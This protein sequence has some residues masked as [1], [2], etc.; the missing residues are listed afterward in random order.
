MGQLVKA[1][2]QA[3]GPVSS[4]WFFL[5]AF[6]LDKEWPYPVGK[7]MEGYSLC[8]NFQGLLWTLTAISGLSQKVTLSPSSSVGPTLNCSLLVFSLTAWCGF[9]PLVWDIEEAWSSAEEDNFECLLAEQT[10]QQ[11]DGKTWLEMVWKC[12][13][14]CLLQVGF[15]S[16]A[17]GHTTDLNWKPSGR[18]PYLE[19]I[20][21]LNM[22]GIMITQWI[23]S[24]SC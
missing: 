3:T 20:S 1:L 8:I 14:S 12:G 18:N 6:H 17:K 11:S 24:F 4:K 21:L 15:N 5:F 9:I 13:E 22:E 10:E 23:P 16:P 19:M 2:L 7:Q